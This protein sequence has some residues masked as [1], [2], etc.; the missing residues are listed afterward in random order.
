[1]GANGTP[2]CR[3]PGSN[4][5]EDPAVEVAVSVPAPALLDLEALQIWS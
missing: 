2:P 3:D 4:G 5:E 1:V